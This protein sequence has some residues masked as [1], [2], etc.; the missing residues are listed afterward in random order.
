MIQ[1]HGKPIGGRKNDLSWA[2]PLLP[3]SDEYR[4]YEKEMMK[5]YRKAGV[6]AVE[7]LYKSQNCDVVSGLGKD[8][9]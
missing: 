4:A 1:E 5:L 6:A 9:A 7:Q 8:A 2:D 3:W